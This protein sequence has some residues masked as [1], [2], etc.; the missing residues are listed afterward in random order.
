MNLRF[1]LPPTLAACV[2]RDAIPIK[3]ELDLGNGKPLPPEKVESDA[4]GSLPDK[5]RAAAFALSNWCGGKIG[6]LL[7]ISPKQLA[8]LI[9]MLRE[10]PC[11][12]FANAP[13]EPI[14]WENGKLLQASA[15][16]EEEST[17]EESESSAIVERTAEEQDSFEISPEAWESYGGR[18]IEVEGSTEYLMVQMPSSEH[19]AYK[20]ALRLLR[21]GNFLRDKQNRHWWWLRD[22]NKVLDFLA[23]HKGTLRDDFEA[24]FTENF[25]KHTKSIREA[26]FKTKALEKDGVS[27]VSVSITAGDAPEAELELAL[28]TGANHVESGGKVYLLDKRMLKKV[29][30]L[31]KE[32]S[33]APDAPLLRSGKYHLTRELATQ[34]EEALLEADPNFSP[35]ESWKSRS[36]VLRDQGKLAMP[37]LD[38]E[39]D[40][41][42]RPYQK[43]G[44]AWM[45]HL[46]RHKLGGILADEM[47][48]G[49]TLQALSLL[50]CLKKNRNLD[51]T[52]LRTSLVVCPASLVENWRRE[53]AR[54]CP[55]LN[56]FRHH[57]SKRLR[58]P[59]EAAPLDLI[60]TSYGTLIRDE[61]L[62]SS[63]EW[64]CVIGD[65]AQH[66]KNRRTRNA[67]ALSK[68][69]SRGRFLL[70]GT[71]VEN[72]IE[73]LRSLVD[74]LMPGALPPVPK[75]SRGEE[76]FWHERRFL[77]QAAPYVLRR[78]KE[79][80][81][82][83]LPEKIEQ[84][85]YVRMTPEQRKAYDKTKSAAETEIAGLEESGA[86]EGAVRMKA[87]TQLL[88]LRQ[89]CCDPRLLDDSLLPEHSAKL[90]GFREILHGVLDGGG[91]ILL[92][93]QFT[94]LLAL[95]RKQLEEE[96][97]PFCYLDGSTTNR[98]AQV[99]LFQDDD[100]IPIF[101]ISLK[102]GG[103][104]L[105]LTGAD[106]VVHFDPWWNPAAEAQATDRAHRIGQTKT[107]HVH[108][109]I[110]ADSVEENVLR[111]QSQ[112]RKLLR[113][114][115]EAS[116]IANAPISIDDLKSLL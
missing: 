40:N 85:V 1:L 113:D 88:R 36:A 69:Q 56:V 116:E 55:D 96:G 94:S 75:N 21:E 3:V 49:K 51:E 103:V 68:L 64:L 12:F 60:V 82:P 45:L 80:V 34:A 4:L 23:E 20:Q 97:I 111:L 92:F 110:A 73:D 67:K 38:E 2:E 84:V 46:F 100:G 17:P 66:V 106:H 86:P 26:T 43:L 32:L 10:C 114:V 5:Q 62:F 11:F 81:A 79:A 105:N 18:P 63:I 108:K 83:E 87:L 104:G 28:S 41:T 77:S 112:K 39:L 27:E 6:S 98:Q 9:G 61:T 115:F 24:T 25:E 70:T 72:S 71:P 65:E 13:A 35:P 76:R 74:F 16:V 8:E 30:D 107:V 57:G 90:A 93:S 14:P 48:L 91:R 15:L 95:V 89:T 53:A 31:Q 37:T 52:H 101:L 22:R 102:A 58:S 47:G 109:L 42:L 59:E 78:A 50:S 54:F 99:D 19:P 44:V 33:G 7:Q 29:H